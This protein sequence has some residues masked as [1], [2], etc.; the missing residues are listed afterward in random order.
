M[1]KLYC[2][3]QQK[4]NILQNS[5]KKHPVKIFNLTEC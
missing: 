2:I 4:V 1:Y 3:I 5:T